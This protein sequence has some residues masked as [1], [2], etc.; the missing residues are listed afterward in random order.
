VLREP[1]WQ[2]DLDISHVCYH[3]DPNASWGLTDHAIEAL[4]AAQRYLNPPRSKKANAVTANNSTLR[5]P[6][7]WTLEM[8]ERSTDHAL[9]TTPSPLR[10]MTT[11]DFKLRGFRTGYSTTAGLV[12]EAWNKKRKKYGGRN[13]KQALVDDAVAHLKDVLRDD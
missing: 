11:I 6:D 9:L 5:I 2:C 7:G 8:L 4:E 10:L 12:G 3:G 13:W 1:C